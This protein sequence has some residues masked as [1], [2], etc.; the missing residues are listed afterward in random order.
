VGYDQGEG[1][2]A[3]LWRVQLPFIDLLWLNDLLRLIMLPHIL[4]MR[5]TL[6][7]L[8]FLSTAH[9]MQTVQKR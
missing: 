5:I 9:S 2:Y 6:Q 7:V 3:F 1:R 4:R 8:C